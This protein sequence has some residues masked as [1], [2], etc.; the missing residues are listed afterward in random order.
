MALRLSRW[1]A[2][3]YVRMASAVRG[4]VRAWLIDPPWP[5][6]RKGGKGTGRASLGFPPLR[7]GG[8]GGF[9]GDDPRVGN[10]IGDRWSP[11]AA[12]TALVTVA[13]VI[14]CALL[15]GDEVT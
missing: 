4:P 3:A 1:A 7:R 10:P 15:R 11:R 14:C 2:V 6:L 13:V 5:P 12:A 8:Q 9:C